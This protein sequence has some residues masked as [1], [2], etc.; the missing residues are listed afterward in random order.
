MK[1]A[2]KLKDLVMARLRKAY[3]DRAIAAARTGAKRRQEAAGIG[4]VVEAA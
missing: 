3:K 2:R 1:I 4:L